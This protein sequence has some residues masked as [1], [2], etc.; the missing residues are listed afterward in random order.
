M[1]AVN[2][3]HCL[4][5]SRVGAEALGQTVACPHCEQFFVA[6]PVATPSKAP[7]RAKRVSTPKRS[8]ADPTPAVTN[9]PIPTVDPYHSGHDEPGHGPHA[10]LIGFVLLPLGI[11][12]LWLA[13]PLLTGR[14]PI[15]SFAAPV[16]L[17][18]GLCGLGLGIGYAH[19]WATATRF[20]AVLSLILVGYFT[21]GTLYFLKKEWAEAVRRHIGPEPGEW[22]LF[23]PPE[24]QYTV[25]APWREQK[26]EGQLPGWSVQ[27][28]RFSP[29]P[30]QA[31][32]QDALGVIYEVAHG[33]P[34]AGLEGKASDDDWFAAARQAIATG[35][36]G[37]IL[38]ERPVTQQGH[39][40][41]EFKVE[42]PDRATNRIIRVFRAENRAFYLAVQGVAIPD[43][44]PYVTRFFTS[45]YIA[46]K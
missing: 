12:L 42:M 25:K 29:N 32:P 23:K 4:Q 26:A 2:C 9:D 11:P 37:E 19:G 40:G 21:G 16:A 44:A 8:I 20:K 7:P 28:Y 34:P 39:V 15:F 30:K 27:G 1:H 18:L 5:W 13:G 36:E 38:R 10:T 3:S 14:E 46:P 41:R 33:S 24:G 35:T 31:V 22:R 17:A 43:D 45:F 6:R